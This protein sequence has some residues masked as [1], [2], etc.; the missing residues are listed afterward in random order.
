MD[1][2]TGVTLQSP[3][4]GS[5]LNFVCVLVR[6][7]LVDGV[8]GQVVV[9]SAGLVISSFGQD[10]LEAGDAALRWTAETMEHGGRAARLSIVAG[11]LTSATLVP[12]L[13]IAPLSARRLAELLLDCAGLSRG[14][15]HAKA[16]KVAR[17]QRRGVDD[18]RL[19]NGSVGKLCHGR[20][21]MHAHRI[22]HRLCA[23]LRRHR[24]EADRQ[25]RI[26][27]I[28][29]TTELEEGSDAAFEQAQVRE[30]DVR[31]P[32]DE[33]VSIPKDYLLKI[34]LKRPPHPRAWTSDGVTLGDR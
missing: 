30:R 16:A 6:Y 24:L 33:L 4:L 3:T 25:I 5:G 18:E 7:K 22:E 2:R 8:V 32:M 27:G 34:R 19:E 23:L 1:D 14:R 20:V 29:E 13:H 12:P 17:M 21:R 10:K 15:V 9:A 11:V 26:L 28:Q 31:R